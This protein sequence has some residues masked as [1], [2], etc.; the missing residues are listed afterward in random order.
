MQKGPAMVD[1]TDARGEERDDASSSAFENSFSIGFQ[2]ILPRTTRRSFIVGSASTLITRPLVAAEPKIP[3]VD[4]SYEDG[5]RRGL[6]ITWIEDVRY[7]WK[8]HASIFTDPDLPGGAGRFVL[9]RTSDGWRADIALCAFPGGYQY[10]LQI[11]VKWDPS[12]TSNASLSIVLVRRDRSIQLDVGDLIAFLKQDDTNPGTPSEIAGSIAKN[13]LGALSQ[14]LFGD[15][16][17]GS[18][19]YDAS[20]AFHRDGYWILRA[21]KAT[22][23]SIEPTFARQDRFAALIG[24]GVSLP[25]QEGFFTIF[26]GSTGGSKRSRLQRRQSRR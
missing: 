23:V 18:R 5:T 20:L 15:T 3:Q 2:S 13:Q 11:F 9:R 7:E 12:S 19:A 6:V 16:F 4:V 26:S 14:A 24:E 1:D 17:D 10:S 21:G 8:L 25:F 22:K